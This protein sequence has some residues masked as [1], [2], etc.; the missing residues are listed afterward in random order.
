MKKLLITLGIAA[1]VFTGFQGDAS[2]VGN[3]NTVNNNDNGTFGTRATTNNNGNGLNGFDLDMNNDNN[4]MRNRNFNT[5]AT[6]ADGNDMDWGWLG[7][8]G[9]V[10]LAG[11][12]GRNRD[13]TTIK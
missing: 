3:G 5:R 12:T 2:A 7:L 8:L 10:G 9:L 4:G 1:V 11:L 13:R 6:A